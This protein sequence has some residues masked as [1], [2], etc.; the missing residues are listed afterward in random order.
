MGKLERIHLEFIANNII[1]QN[2]LEDILVQLFSQSTLES[3]SV[4]IDRD[5]KIIKDALKRTLFVKRKKLRGKFYI[6]EQIDGAYEYLEILT[7]KIKE[8]TDDYIL[9]FRCV[10][11][12]NMV[13][14]VTTFGCNIGDILRLT[15]TN[16]NC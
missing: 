9:K 4:K 2:G 15:R 6:K 11:T 12:E 7:D 16:G 8:C 10:L 14:K 1:G 3:I 5:V 13:N